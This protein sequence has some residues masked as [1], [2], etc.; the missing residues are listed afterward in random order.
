MSHTLCL[1]TPV[2][3]RDSLADPLALR[4]YPGFPSNLIL[5]LIHPDNDPPGSHPSPSPPPWTNSKY[6][7]HQS[8]NRSPHS[9]PRSLKRSA[10]SWLKRPSHCPR[11]SPTWS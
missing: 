8:S 5:V 6:H 10:N 3:S 2:G 9:S 1:V 7:N 4:L 11:R